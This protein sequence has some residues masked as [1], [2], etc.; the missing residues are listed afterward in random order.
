MGGDKISVLSLYFISLFAIIIE[1]D[2]SVTPESFKMSASIITT[3]TRAVNLSTVLIKYDGAVNWFFVI[4]KH[5][6]SI[7]KFVRRQLVSTRKY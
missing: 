4:V 6:I 5:F 3:R 1:S 2:L 7:Q